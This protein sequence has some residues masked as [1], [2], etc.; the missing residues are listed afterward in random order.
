MLA[1]RSSWPFVQLTFADSGYQGPRVAQAS[2]IRVEI[3]RKP[4]GQ[5]GF[6]VHARRWVVERFFAWINRNRRLA[7]DVEATIKSAFLYTASAIMLL[8]RLA[9]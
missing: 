2:T 9:R 7:K 6:A 1:S 4:E 5:I 8:R 3:V